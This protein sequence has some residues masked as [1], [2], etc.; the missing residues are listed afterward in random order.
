MACTLW[1]T[2]LPASGK[3]T[4]AR[5]VAQALLARGERV[6]VLDGDEIRRHLSHGLGFSRADR[7]ENLRRIAF[8]A[9]LLSRNGVHAISAAIAPFRTGRDEV[10]LRLGSRFVEVYLDAPVE[11]CARRDPK[12]LYAR[13][14][15]GE[16]ENFTGVSDPYEPPHK[17]ELT[18]HTSVESPHESAARVLAYLDELGSNRPTRSRPAS[19]LPW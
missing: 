19:G 12:G 15:S 17:P 5:L 14:F 11:V 16:I 9:D 18:L 13:A 6:E 3:S 10:R 4:V 8:V 2:G 7:E 1:F